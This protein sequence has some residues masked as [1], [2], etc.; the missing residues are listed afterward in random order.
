MF[1]FDDNKCY[2]MPV[3]L[4]GWDYNPSGVYYRDVM[5]INYRI[6][7]DGDRLA[8]FLP[9]GFELLRPE[10]QIGY[11]QGREIE[12]M[13]GSGY[14]LI[15][16]G[17]PARFQGELDRVEGV[18]SLVVWENKT[19]PILGGREESGVPKIFADI[20]D[21][22]KFQQNYFTNASYEGNTFLRLELTEAQAV[23]P[24]PLSGDRA[25]MNWRYIPNV[26]G[27]GAA[28]SQP[29][30]YPQR[31]EVDSAWVGKGT[32]QWTQQ[33]WAQNPLQ[34]PY[35]KALAEL[36]VIEMAPAVLMKGMAILYSNQCRV[37]A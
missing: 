8:D 6:T 12:W 36:P 22:H 24:K 28:L 3:F 27:P 18:F 9:E 16:V 25:L 23:D 13:A 26:G 33:T 2:K 30:L 17:V 1:K 34:W 37:L 11:M 20:E 31:T 4:G 19:A 21:L 29:I 14:N 7:T 5:M 35:I 15:E 32:V 10:L